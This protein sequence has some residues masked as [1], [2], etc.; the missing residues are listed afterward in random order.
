MNFLGDQRWLIY[1]LPG[2]IALFV[3][4]FISDFPQIRDSQL[5]IVYIA[6]TAM[7]VAIPLLAVH[8]YGK[9]RGIPFEFDS[10][11]RSP[12]V[13]SAIFFS[14]VVLGF[15]FGV[16]H[17]TDYVSRGLRG[18]FGK[19]I[20]LTSSHS[21]LIKVLFKNAYNEKFTDGQPHLDSKYKRNHTN[22]Y[23]IF[24]FAGD[25]KSYEGVVAEFFGTNDKP[26]VYLSPACSIEK[27]DPIVVRGPGVWLNLEGL[28][29]IQFVYSVCSKC[30]SELELAAGNEPSKKCPFYNASAKLPN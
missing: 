12:M 24:T 20:V 1:V 22:R 11:I 5:P 21:E 14:S 18:V 4:S 26:Q 28:E 23:A 8:I 15:V 27:G 30:A 3:A 29:D 16:A 7:S 2:F 25:R 10:T 19:D 13:L 6:L 17:T 9:L